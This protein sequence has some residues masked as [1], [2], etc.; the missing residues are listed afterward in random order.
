MPAQSYLTHDNGGRPF[1]VDI[2]A[3][4]KTVKLHQ[5]VKIDYS[6]Y[7]HAKDY[8]EDTYHDEP[9]MVWRH[10]KNVFVGDSPKTDMTSFSCGFGPKF[11]GNSILLHLK[12]LEYVFIG[13]NV[14]QF[15]AK[16]PIVKYVSEVGNNDVPYPYAVDSKG[17]IYLLIEN[18]ILTKHLEE[19]TNQ[20]P[21]HWY[22][23]KTLMTEDRAVVH[24]G[25]KPEW[26][27]TNILRFYVGSQSFTMRTHP[28]PAKDYDYMTRWSKHSKKHRPVYITVRGH[29]KIELSKN[30]YVKLLTSFNEKHGFELLKSELLFPRDF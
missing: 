6:R 15:A 30:D 21:Y 18:V 5:R 11:R 1:R 20:G 12:G 10:V 25:P 4:G 27:R 8:P 16:S 2:S 24:R 17:R 9:A 26:T 3:D 29:G 14:F 13:M 28:D 22:Y 23:D 7:K 19:A